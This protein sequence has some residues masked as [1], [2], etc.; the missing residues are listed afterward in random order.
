MFNIPL[1]YHSW[2]AGTKAMENL[3][4]PIFSTECMQLVMFM[5]FRIFSALP[6]IFIAQ[7]TSSDI[8]Q[9]NK[10][11]CLHY[12]VL[13]VIS[14]HSRCSYKSFFPDPDETGPNH[15]Q[16][17]SWADH[18]YGQVKE[19][20]LTKSTADYCHSIFLIISIEFRAQ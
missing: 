17:L 12:T 3:E 15:C 20:F 1:V 14:F 6:F 5:R 10:Q 13:Y 4:F 19:S 2:H 8:I 9:L 11:T 7:P 18:N 16:V